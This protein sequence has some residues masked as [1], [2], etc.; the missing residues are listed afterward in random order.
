MGEPSWS[1]VLALPLGLLIFRGILW[2]V[3]KAVIAYYRAWCRR[4]YPDQD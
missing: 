1:P 3:E 2:L 4:R